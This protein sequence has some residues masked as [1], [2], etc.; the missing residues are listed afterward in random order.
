MSEFEEPEDFD[1][2][3][4]QMCPAPPGTVVH[5][6]VGDGMIEVPC[7]MF[8]LQEARAM[9]TVRADETGVGARY[10]EDLTPPYDTRVV[11]GML[12]EFSC[13]HQLVDAAYHQVSLRH[14]D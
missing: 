9:I 7:P 14:N 13:G 2:V 5:V 11:P 4:V 1:W 3:T 12:Y 6:P 10:A 8:L